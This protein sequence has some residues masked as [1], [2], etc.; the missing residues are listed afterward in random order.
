MSR[1]KGSAA[2]WAAWRAGLKDLQ[3]VALQPLPGSMQ[4]VSEAGSIANNT[5]IEVHEEKHPRQSKPE[6]EMERE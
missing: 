2:L 3:Q 5:V 1:P 4:T 6:P